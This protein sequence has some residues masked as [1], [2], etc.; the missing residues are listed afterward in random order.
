VHFIN[1][2]T[3]LSDRPDKGELVRACGVP[4]EQVHI[5]VGETDEVIINSA[6]KLG[7]NMVVIGNSHRTGLAALIYTNTAEK[8][9]DKLDCNL[10]ALP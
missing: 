8:I 2:Y 5:E 3:Q 6:R 9:L 10:L 4:S 1:A 7:A